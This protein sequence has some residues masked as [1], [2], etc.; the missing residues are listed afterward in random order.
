MRWPTLRPSAK[1]RNLL[2]PSGL[3]LPALRGRLISDGPDFRNNNFSLLD[4]S[5]LGFWGH[6]VTR[7]RK[8]GVE[9][10]HEGTN[11]RALFCSGDEGKGRG[12]VELADGDVFQNEILGKGYKLLMDN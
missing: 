12:E 6:R 11:F 3:A 7:N 2:F 1:A 5:H 8:V 10:Q 9:I 4:V